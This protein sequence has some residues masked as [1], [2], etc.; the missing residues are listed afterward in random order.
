MSGNSIANETISQKRTRQPFSLYRFLTNKYFLYCVSVVLFLSLWDYVAREKIFRDS[1]ARPLE[2]WDQL[3]L[4]TQI[5]FAGTHLW[6]HI[7][8]SLQRVLIGFVLASVVAIPLGLFMALNKYVNAIVK[9][10]F[11]LFK[12]MPPI[13]WVSIAILWFGMGETSKVFIIIIGTF[14][15]CLLNA[16]NGVRLVDPELYDVIRVLGGK[17]RDEIIHVCFPA[18]F[19]AIFAG[20]QISLSSAWTCVL[21]AELMNSRNGMGF[22]IKRGMDT[23]QPTLVLGGMILIAAAACI[24]SLVITMAERKLCPWQ[25]NIENL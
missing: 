10:L 2:V 7:W 17:R 15:P 4:L 1:L 8:A 14:V 21:A 16:Y 13:A 19:P 6:G 11:D 18:S 9:P 23:H 24:T 3:V 25:R 12:P 5:K 22:L 20:L